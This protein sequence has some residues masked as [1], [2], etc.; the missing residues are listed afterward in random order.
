[1]TVDDDPMP[2]SEPEQLPGDDQLD[3]PDED[4]DVGQEEPAGR[5]HRAP[6][7][8]ATADIAERQDAPHSHSSESGRPP[9][10]APAY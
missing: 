7:D 2:L 10:D 3:D 1:M 6:S 4:P 5:R 8:D 9:D